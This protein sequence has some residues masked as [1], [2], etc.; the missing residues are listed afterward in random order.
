MNFSRLVN[1]WAWRVN[2]GMPDPLNRTHVEFLR[3]VLRESG[4]GEDFIMSYTQNLTEAG[5]DDKI[6]KY[7]DKDGNAAEM[8]AAAAK[9]QSEDHPAKIAWQKTQD[10][11]TGNSTEKPDPQ[12]LSGTD[13]ERSAGKKKE[14][15]T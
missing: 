8:K 13:F 12:Q 7:K 11:D 14:K 3:D 9:K 6:I 2:D 15:P 5:E 4:Y 10:D 1:E